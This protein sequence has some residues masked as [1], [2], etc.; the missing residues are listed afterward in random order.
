MLK[1]IEN[2]VEKY[3]YFKLSVKKFVSQFSN[4]QGSDVST[5]LGYDSSAQEDSPGAKNKY[6]AE[7]YQSPKTPSTNFKFME[8]PDPEKA[9][10]INPKIVYSLIDDEDNSSMIMGRIFEVKKTIMNETNNQGAV[11][12][13]NDLR[14]PKYINLVNNIKYVEEDRFYT[15]VSHLVE[16]E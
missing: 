8:C 9:Q 3:F 10:D 2:E 16:E 4:F 7:L 15:K 12:E 6:S 14:D 5:T 13:F 1:I 11:E